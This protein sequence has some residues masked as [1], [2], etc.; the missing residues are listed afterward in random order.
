MTHALDDST[1]ISSW[2]QQP[3]PV[4]LR[5]T[6]RRCNRDLRAAEGILLAAVTGI[7]LIAWAYVLFRWLL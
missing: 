2:I 1:T 3:G 4:N 5:V 7:A 6:P